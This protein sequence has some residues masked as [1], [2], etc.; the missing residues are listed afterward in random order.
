LEKYEYNRITKQNDWRTQMKKY[1]V[2]FYIG[3][4]QPYH[5]GHHSIVQAMQEQCE[6][7]IIGL[8][9]AQEERTPRNP[10]S[11]ALRTKMIY[12]SVYPSYNIR[13]I[14]IYDRPVPANDSRWGDYVMHQVRETT[15][16]VPDVIFEGDEVERESWFAN[17]GLP[18]VRIPRTE[19]P[20]SGTQIREIIKNEDDPYD[21][22]WDYIPWGE[23]RNVRQMKKVMRGLEN[24]NEN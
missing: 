2:G 24:A 6:H 14:P 17:T 8:G 7:I 20:I 16:V 23:L 18:I 21:T 12:D 1:K 3:R 15:G 11:V 4:F 13:I 10:F 5:K 19:I 9:S 22:L